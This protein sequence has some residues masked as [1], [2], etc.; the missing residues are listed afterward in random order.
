MDTHSPSPPFRAAPDPSHHTR[1]GKRFIL[2]SRYFRPGNAVSFGVA[3]WNYVG[4]ECEPTRCAKAQLDRQQVHCRNARY[5]W[6]C[7]CAGE[8]LFTSW[9][10]ALRWQERGTAKDLICPYHHW[11]F[12]LNGELAAS[13]ARLRA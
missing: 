4:L 11:R 9:N 13:F 10:T 7:A 5:Q 1:A 6:W 8:S 2:T 12:E 3:H